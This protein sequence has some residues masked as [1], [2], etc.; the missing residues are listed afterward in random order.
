MQ[1]KTGHM[2]DKNS[3]TSGK[4][5][6]NT[7]RPSKDVGSKDKG[8][9]MNKIFTEATRKW[10]YGI[11]VALGA[12]A[13]FYGFMTAEEVAVWLGVLVAVTGITSIAHVGEKG[14]DNNVSE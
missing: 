14:V 8:K 5:S 3:T 12:A 10:I 4:N 6:T 1:Q 7:T 11:A 9:E 2:L 13:V